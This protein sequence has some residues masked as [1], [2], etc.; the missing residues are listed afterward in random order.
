MKQFFFS[1]MH[2]ILFTLLPILGML[3]LTIAYR[4]W[5]TSNNIIQNGL[6]TEGV[7]TGFRNNTDRQ[8]RTSNTIAPNVQFKTQK[9]E[10]ITYYS[11]TYTSPSPYQEGQIVPIWYLPDN[12]QEATIKG[13]DLYLLPLIFGGFGALAMLF[14]LPTI[15]RFLIG[16]MYQ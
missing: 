4:T 13:A 5:S 6:K 14:S 12:P 1:N 2:S 10:L 8:K 11:T 9:G 7:V 16:L 15:L 3:F